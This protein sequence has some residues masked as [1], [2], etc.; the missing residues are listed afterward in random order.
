[1]IKAMYKLA[2]GEHSLE[3]KKNFCNHYDME[4][5]FSYKCGAVFL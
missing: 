1:M 3:I 4:Q 5:L 2:M